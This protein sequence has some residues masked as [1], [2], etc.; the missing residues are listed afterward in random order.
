[1]DFEDKK[2]E[3]AELEREQR[4]EV[5]EE[6]QEQEE[7][8]PVLAGEEVRDGELL[9]RSR[10]FDAMRSIL[11]GNELGI[12]NLHL[13]R[14]ASEALEFLQAAVQGRDA[15]GQFVYAEDRASMLEQALAV[16][17]ENLTHGDAAELA[18]LEATYGEMTERVA[19]L[20]DELTGLAEAQ[21]DIEHLLQRE[22]RK[23]DGEDD[24]DDARD[25]DGDQAAADV[26]PLAD[27]L[28]APAL[29]ERPP[30]VSTLSDGGPEAPPRR[31]HVSTLGE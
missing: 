5:R 22:A 24:D 2:L 14:R 11:A 25:G 20:R 27:Y 31:D 23:D 30:H 17:Q 9:H 8:L 1:M 28:R 26:E 19:E 18:Q 12:G 29:P 16:L 6:V 15:R 13:P 10:L 21:D 3:G 7:E 4:L